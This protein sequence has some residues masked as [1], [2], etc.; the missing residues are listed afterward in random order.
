MRVWVKSEALGVRV[1]LRLKSM[2]LHEP[3]NNRPCISFIFWLNDLEHPNKPLKASGEE[4][5]IVPADEV[6]H[7]P[8][9]QAADFQLNLFP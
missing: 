1:T 8:R 4:V 2:P 3:L 9:R 5:A 7:A 6:S